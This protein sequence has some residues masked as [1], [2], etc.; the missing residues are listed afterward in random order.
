MAKELIATEDTDILIGIPKSEKIVGLDTDDRLYGKD[1][2]DTLNGLA[3]ND[4]LSVERGNTQL[5]GGDGNDTLNT[6]TVRFDEVG[7]NH[8]LDGGK[9]NDELSAGNGNDLLEGG[10]GIDKLTSSDG[11][12][13]LKGGDGDDDLG[14]GEGGGGAG[15][16]QL[17]GGEGNDVLNGGD[18]QD[19]LFGNA[20]NDV[21]LGFEGNDI[22]SGG[23]GADIFVIA[24]RIGQETLVDY[25]DGQDKFLLD[26]GSLNPSFSKAPELTFEQ[27]KITQEGSNI[28][29]A[30]ADS[31]EI[32]ATVE[33]IQ[34]S[35]I[36]EEDFISTTDMD[37]NQIEGDTSQEDKMPSI[38]G[39]E[40]STN[41]VSAVK[42][43]GDQAIKA[44]EARKFFDVDGSG[45]TIGVLSDS[46]DRS[47]TASTR[48]SDG[49]AS[50]DLPGQGNPNGYTTPVR[51]LDDSSDN[52][53]G[54]LIDEGRAMME[55]IH[56]VAPG[57]ELVFHTATKGSEDYAGA[58]NELVSAGADIIVDDTINL[59]EP[60]FQDGIVAQ[61]ADEASKAG[62]AYFSA[63]G[64]FNRN[65]YESE[66]RPIEYEENLPIAE[67]DRKR[68]TLHDFNPDPSIDLLQGITLEPFQSA[69]FVLNWDES[70][71]SAGGAG[72]KSDLDLFVLDSQ[73]NIVST[74]ITNNLGKDAVESVLISNDTEQKAQYNLAIG[75]DRF[76][77]GPLPKQ[78]KYVIQG[79]AEIEYATNSSTITGHGNATN[80]MTVGA[81]DYLQTP[82]FGTDP[83]KVRSSSSAGETPILLDPQGNI[84]SNPEIR[85]KPDVVAPNSVNTSFFGSTDIEGD[86]FPNFIGT[87]A[88][89]PYAAAT[90]ALMLDAVPSTSPDEI[91][92]IIRQ[93]ALD[94]DDP[95][96][97]GFDNGFD[98][99]SG[100]GLIQADLALQALVGDSNSVVI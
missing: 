33:G 89:A 31:D 84:L 40:F 75:F 58:I 78:L 60:Y 12:D 74:G 26:L 4:F 23:T 3:G 66:F 16:D 82:T 37:E 80:V 62:V 65:S 8:R 90:A 86:G 95:S 43:Q 49:V 30:I 24:P 47:L 77:G 25:Q 29:I 45:I 100:Y 42:S 83:A 18:G 61:A 64:N 35:A 85:Q 63:A 41:S 28:K 92:D 27:L 69:I 79:Q 1:G 56:D 54:G 81:A 93:T 59:D 15:D 97:I 87:S 34:A 7:G 19:G 11:N 71:D 48:A 96:T 68:Y 10:K 22:L 46:Y 55:L 2:D 98:F 76:A 91:Y 21:L 36:T 6:F 9:G 73:N 13:T 94:M 52:S 51:I 70:F 72:S 99:A 88:A 57:A 53:N 67:I 14:L 17:F 32:L 5:I 38:Q 50:G 39:K 44:D 20:G